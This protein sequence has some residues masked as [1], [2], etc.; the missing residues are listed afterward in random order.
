MTRTAE[1]RH[2]VLKL[3]RERP[4]YTP[5]SLS[6][7]RYDLF[8]SHS[9]FAKLCGVSERTIYRIEAG[10]PVDG[11]TIARIADATGFDPLTLSEAVKRSVRR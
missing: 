4:N 3:H 6:A 7:L 2:A 9:D 8:M 5:R 10:T 1:L 11:D